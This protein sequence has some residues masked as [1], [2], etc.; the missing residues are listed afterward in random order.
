M[1][2]LGA[3]ARPFTTNSYLLQ[4]SIFSAVRGMVV[5]LLGILKTKRLGPDKKAAAGY[6]LASLRSKA[7]SAILCGWKKTAK[8][9]SPPDRSNWL[10]AP[11][12]K[13]RKDIFRCSKSCGRKMLRLTCPSI[14]GRSSSEKNRAV[15]G[16]ANKG[17]T[18]K[19][20]PINANQLKKAR[21]EAK[22]SSSPASGSVFGTMEF[23]PNW[24][25][26]G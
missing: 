7:C 22:G 1:N 25:P 21:R 13:L 16:S 23:M 4:S 10:P 6:C 2:L 11:F 14:G 12:L 26:M 19:L 5:T 24:F 17:L 8:K 15:L 3:K 9:A 20:T 18:G